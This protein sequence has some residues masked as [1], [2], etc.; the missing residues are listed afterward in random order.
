MAQ[1]IKIAGERT[2]A[3]WRKLSAAL[4]ADMGNTHLWEVAF[5]YL[6]ERMKTRYLS[7]IKHIEGNGDND[8]E[9]FAIV[10]I[11]C[12]MVE[13]LESFY[14]GKSYRKA[15]KAAPLDPSAEYYES[16]PI[17]VSF[18]QNREPFRNHFAA[19]GLATEFYKNVRCPILHE[20]ATRCG[21]KIRIDS[22]NLIE[23]QG[24]DWI[25]NRALFVRAIE[26]YMKSYKQELFDSPSPN[27][28]N[29]FIRKFDAICASA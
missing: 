11:I 27:L 5:G 2:V 6:E 4:L 3:D 16:Q 7:P 12:S 15:T 9:G 29:A 26:E 1:D 14:E 17:F 19:S 8:G 23:Q 22:K 21:W 28:K 13:A 24:N 20:A 18:L 10:A 25:L